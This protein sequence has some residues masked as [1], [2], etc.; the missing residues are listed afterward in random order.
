LGGLP[1]RVVQASP[2]GKEILRPSLASARPRSHA[3]LE[4]FGMLYAPGVDWLPFDEGVPH[5]CVARFACWW[6]CAGS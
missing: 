5:S 3:N 2:I 6:L 4:C 1:P